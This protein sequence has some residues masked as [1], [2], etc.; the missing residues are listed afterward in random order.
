MLFQILNTKV[1]PKN[2]F[3]KC[4]NLAFVKDPYRVVV[5]ILIFCSVLIF[6]WIKNGN[7]TL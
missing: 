1:D 7:I 5:S 4:F 3:K 2:Q 6:K